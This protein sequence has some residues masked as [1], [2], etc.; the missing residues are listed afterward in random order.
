MVSAL[1]TIPLL[2]QHID[3]EEDLV[4]IVVNA[5]SRVEAN[6][7]LGMLRESVSERV[8]VAALNLREVL[9]SL[10]G[11]PCSMAIDETT[12][13]RVAGLT[14][15]RSAWTKPLDDDPDITLSVSTAGN[16]CF[17]LAVGIDGRS[18]FWTPP[19]A[20]EDFV[21]PELLDACLDRPALLPAVIA[22]TEDMGLVFNPRFY[23]SVD[24]WNLD[25]LQESFEDF[26]AIF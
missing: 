15:D 19:S 20:E 24:D 2:K 23:M 3:A 10:P 12:L 18:I 8:L 16:F 5:R 21:H 6:L 9:D 11:Y 7:A 26:R 25:H 4:R 22:L 14:K 1:A 13:S 17:D